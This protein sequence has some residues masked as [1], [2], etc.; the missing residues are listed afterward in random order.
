MLAVESL[1][2]GHPQ[3]TVGRDVSFALDALF[4]TAS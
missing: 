4:F 1:A 3:R 2:F